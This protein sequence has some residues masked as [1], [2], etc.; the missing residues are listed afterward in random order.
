MYKVP[1]QVLEL[2]LKNQETSLSRIQRLDH[3]DTKNVLPKTALYIK[4]LKRSI[5]ELKFYLGI[6]E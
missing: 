1:I 5:K 3:K 4:N 2:A 6:E